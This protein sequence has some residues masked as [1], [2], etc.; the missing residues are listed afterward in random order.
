MRLKSK[1]KE[2][3]IL[4]AAIKVFARD[5]FF[6]A[7]VHSIAD[8]AKVAAGSVY[9]YYENKDA[10]LLAIF[11]NIWKKL[12]E[13]LLKIYQRDDLSPIDKFDGMIDLVF[14]VLITNREQAIVFVN[15]QHHFQIK[16]KDKF[17]KYY[18]KFLDLGEE[19]VKEGIEKKLFNSNFNIKI[20]RSFVFGGARHLIR[21]WA[22]NPKDYDLNEIRQ[23]VKHVLKYGLIKK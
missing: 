13:G 5:G 11:E 1:E 15:E 16:Y 23:T 3:N 9:L 10:L 21:T 17:T 7:K 18:D 14:D 22:H 2:E 20:L 8:E 19:I 12:Y 6:N 4:K